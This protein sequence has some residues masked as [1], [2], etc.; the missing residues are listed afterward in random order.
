MNRISII[1]Q[2]KWGEPKL[3]KPEEIN[4]KPNF[5]ITYSNIEQGKC[6]CPVYII[7]NDMYIL[8]RDWHSNSM[9]VYNYNSKYNQNIS[10]SKKRLYDDG[11]K[12]VIL[13]DEAWIKLTDISECKLNDIMVEMLIN[14]NIFDMADYRLI[15]DAIIRLRHMSH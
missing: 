13:R 7:D 14:N 10:L 4:G 3:K 1:S 15:S 11:I 6:K 5:S 9:N 2:R 12:R 8:H